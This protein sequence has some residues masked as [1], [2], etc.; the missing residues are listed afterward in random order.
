MP[1]GETIPRSDFEKRYRTTDEAAFR[2]WYEG[3]AQRLSLSRD[4]DDPRHKY[5]YRAAF[6]AGVVPDESGHWPSQ[7]K[8][9][10]HPDRFVGSVDTKTGVETITREEF[11]RR[12]ARHGATVGWESPSVSGFIANV[13]K[14]A[15]RL[16]EDL[17]TVMTHPVQT[18]KAIRDVAVGGLERAR[19]AV[20]IPDPTGKALR[21][22]SI[23]AFDAFADHLKDRYGN[24]ANIKRTAYDDPVGFLLDISALLTAGGTAA[25]RAGLTT[26]GRTLSRAGELSDPIRG[27]V[28][29]AE[30]AGAG[31]GKVLAP[32]LGKTTGV[33]ANAIR[34]AERGSEA[35]TQAMRG[36]LTEIEIVDEVR[37]ALKDLVDKRNAEYQANLAKLPQTVQH[38]LRPVQ[39]S[40]RDALQQTGVR[41]QYDRQT[42]RYLASFDRAKGITSAA[43]QN[44]I[45]QAIDILSGWGTKSGDLT[46]AGVDTLKQQLASLI[47]GDGS[48][49]DR[50]IT[51]VHNRSRELLET[52]VPGYRDMTKRYSDASGFLRQVQKELSTTSDNPGQAIRKLSTAL[53]QR[54]EYRKILLEMLDQETGSDIAGA[55]AGAEMRSVAP[56]GLMGSVF[57]HG[58]SFGGGIAAAFRSPEALAAL[59]MAAA[60]SSPRFIG[61]ALLAIAR[62]RRAKA[63]LPKVPPAAAAAPVRNVV[64][65]TTEYVNQDE[66]DY[67]ISTGETPESL[68]K[69]GIVLRK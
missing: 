40:M 52:R 46:T 13:P 26:T 31:T 53:N 18:V 54:N 41:V 67:L 22:E 44:R 29:A 65:S 21:T 3:W 1:V 66:W 38:D 62:A 47:A 39:Q 17:G 25:G 6:R 30:A 2:K 68:A 48:R 32:V 19:Q 63:A 10:D 59:A 24:W 57:G 61:E 49:A 36:D 34:T 5:D 58:L 69:E 15:G 11:S 50:I 7:F 12:Y 45:Q 4:P 55:I 35:F 23:P 60:V 51:S 16:A 33:G 20:P 56:H 27:A 14:S 64:A 43:E 42:G 8:A 28:R 9:D 37:V